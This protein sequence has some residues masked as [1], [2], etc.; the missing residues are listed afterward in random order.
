MFPEIGGRGVHLTPILTM[1]LLIR[2]F[3]GPW[4]SGY[5]FKKRKL[6]ILIAIFRSPFD[7]A[8][9]WMPRAFIVGSCNGLVPSGNKPLSEPML[10]KFYVAMWRHWDTM[11]WYDDFNRDEI[12]WFAYYSM[13][14]LHQHYDDVVKWKHP[15]NNIWSIWSR[16][17]SLNWSG[18]TDQKDWI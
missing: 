9:R 1:W 13:I 8:P 3:V 17:C 2:W 5:D 12:S 6:V 10:T 16:V 14:I 4:K 7:N 15:V 11:N 18:Y